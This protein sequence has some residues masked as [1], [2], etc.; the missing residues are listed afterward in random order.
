MRRISTGVYGRSILGD[1]AVDNNQFK[2]LDT[3][4]DIVFDPDGT[5]SVRSLSNIELDSSAGLIFQE[6]GG[7]I[8]LQTNTVS[9]SYTLTLPP[10]NG[11]QNTVLS[12]DGSGNLS[13]ED[14][15]VN[16]QNQTTDNSTYFPLLTTQTSG[17][18]TSVSTS[19]TKLS[20][21][22][23]SGNLTLAGNISATGS[24]SGASADFNGTVEYLLTENLKNASHTLE[25]AD[26][27]K[28]VAFDTSS[29]E[30]CTI[31]NES[32]VDFPIGSIVYISRVGAGDLTL[33]GASGV[34]LTREGI[35]AN[36]EELYVRKR[37]SNS[38]IVVDV[39]RSPSGSG[40]DVTTD[41]G[42]TVHTFESTGTFAVS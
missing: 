40:G 12:T 19:N 10:S 37:A 33:T 35:L 25:L 29:D 23:S 34:A 39:P 20:F 28:V 3:D 13:W 27:N 24:I 14:V 9:S 31:P 16:I 7:N 38:W 8:T 18:I 36:A 11:A 22:P 21:Q 17:G 4:Q 1:F 2:S 5:G 41:A 32:S 26:R 15:A 42:D 6:N 30:T